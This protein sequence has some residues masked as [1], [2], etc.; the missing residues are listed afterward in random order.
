MGNGIASTPPKYLNISAFPSITGSDASG[1][2][3]P[4]PRTLLPLVITAI[5]FHR[6]VSLKDSSLLC[7]IALETAATPGVYQIAKSLNDL[8]GTFGTVSILP[9]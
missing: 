8:T 1:P 5:V 3:F 9:P 7:A 4:S 2:M 6:L